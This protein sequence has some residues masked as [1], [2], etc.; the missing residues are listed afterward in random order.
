VGPVRVD[1]RFEAGRPAFA[2]FT[3]AILPEHRAS[4]LPRDEMARLV[5]LETTDLSVDLPPEM[6]SC[7][8]PFHVIPIASLDAIRRAVLDMSMWTRLVAPLWANNVYLVCLETEG[9]GADVHVR[10]FGPRSGVPED[11]GTGAAAAALGGYLASSDGGVSGSLS[12]IVEQGKECG[13]PSRLLVEA[14]RAGG[15]T[16]AVRV[17]GA[18]VFVSR[19]V[20]SVPEDGGE[21]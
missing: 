17:G 16:V 20:M 3:T 13:R 11:P 14:D 10:M 6:V 18:A 1:V 15:R 21:S 9:E 7:G 8:V 5:G 4:P 12:W 2:R 19:G